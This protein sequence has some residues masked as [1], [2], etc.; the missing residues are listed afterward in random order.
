VSLNFA[1]AVRHEAKARVAIIGPTGAGKTWTA[2]EWATV[3]GNKVAVIDTENGSA[4]LYSDQYQFDTAPWAPPYNASKL[5][6]AIGEAAAVYD[7]I[8]LDSLTHFW[9]GEGGVLD[10]VDQESIKNRGNTYA[11][12]KKGTPVWRGLLDALIYAPCHVIVTMRSKM[13]YVQSQVDGRTKIEKVGMAPVARND[14][15]Y[16]F[17]LVGELDQSHRLTVTKSRCAPLADMVAAPHQ[18][19]KLAVVLRDWLASAAP[20][21]EPP[22]A[23][24][25]PSPEMAGPKASQ[26]QIQRLQIMFGEANIAARDQRLTYA[27][28]V[29]SREIKTSKDLTANECSKVIASLE[30]IVAELNR[31]G[32]A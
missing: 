8:V 24:P 13:D 5:A 26:A 20:A 25:E 32:S 1:P 31:Q 6:A 7:V 14:V 11:G 30:L 4:S 18:A 12:W 2:L 22:P 23:P 19:E 16:E 27:A 28:G 10:I 9:Q 15:E 17:T 3:L 29:I 21:P